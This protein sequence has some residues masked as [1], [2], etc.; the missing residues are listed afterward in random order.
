MKARIAIAVSC[1]TVALGAVAASSAQ[2]P[3]TATVGWRT[4]TSGCYPDAIPP[5]HWS[6]TSNV[7][8]AA[9]MPGRSAATPVPVSTKLIV[10]ADP[11][12]LLAVDRNTGRILWSVDNPR[13]KLASQEDIAAAGAGKKEVK[14]NKEVG[15]SCCTPVSDGAVAVALFNNGMLV[16]YDLEGKPV[17]TRYISPVRKGYGQSMSPAIAGNVVG[18]H[19]DDTMYGV[20][21]K[22]GK[23]LWKD[24]ELQHQGS[25][26]GMRVGTLDVFFT[27][28]GHVRNSTDGRILKKVDGS[29]NLFTTPARSGDT[30]YWIAENRRLMT[31][32]FLPQGADGIQAKASGSG[33][34]KGCY[35]AS[36]LVTEPYIYAW[37]NIDY[38]ARDK[39]LHVFDA[40]TRKQ[41]GDVTLSVG[42]WAYASPTAAGKFIYVINSTGA[43]TVLA[44]Q[45][46]GTHKTVAVNQLDPMSACPVFEKDRMYARTHKT[47]YCIV[48]SAADRKEAASMAAQTK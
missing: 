31:C 43:C 42:G 9:P 11:A 15:G 23:T 1:A 39:M 10:V 33:I 40:K 32:Q 24:Y 16:C 28:E 22:T 26:V 17:W 35:Y 30:W 8:W 4:D 38:K 2:T 5:L 44:A 27:C 20:D 3:R 14:P 12:T 19:I 7:L 21:L 29:L 36:V 41:V 47:L 13:D 34:P 37:N 18:V 45:R 46:D 6:S 48:T 25:P